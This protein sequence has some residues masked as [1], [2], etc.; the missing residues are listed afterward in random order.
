MKTRLL[1]VS[2]VVLVTLL[3]GAAVASPGL[4][5][6]VGPVVANNAGPSFDPQSVQGQWFRRVNPTGGPGATEVRTHEFYDNVTGFGGGA[7]DHLAIR[8]I[9]GGLTFV[10]GNPGL[11]SG[12]SIIAS[13]TNNTPA[14]SG[15]WR[16]GSNLHGERLNTQQN[17]VGR[18]LGVKLTTHWADDGVQGNW[19]SGGPN[20]PSPNPIPNSTNPSGESNTYAVG[21]D[22]LGWYSHSTATP[23]N[24]QGQFSVPTW[25]FGDIDVGQTK[26]RDLVFSFYAPVPLTSIN[27]QI[28][29]STDFLIGRTNDLKIGAAFQADPILNSIIDTGAAYPFGGLPGTPSAEYAN[30]SVFFN[31]P[32]P[33]AA[34]LL[35]LS[36][37]VA[38]G[39]RRR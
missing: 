15:E 18:M 10:P 35:A 28:L 3:A 8:G 4:D 23:N 32:S 13:V 1:S 11:V 20:L 16:P 33:A 30:V 36:G 24:P 14:V 7:P 29:G 17:Y 12:Y 6:R 31:V 26:F 21:Y 38:V 25:D 22:Q 9:F 19:N 39:R 34:S 37:L 2:S 27:T 5:I